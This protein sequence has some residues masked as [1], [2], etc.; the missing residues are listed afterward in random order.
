MSGNELVYG[1]TYSVVIE[2][3]I[4]AFSREMIYTAVLS[5][6]GAV[7][8]RADFSPYTGLSAWEGDPEVTD[9][10]ERDDAL[11]HELEKCATSA[12][13]GKPHQIAEGSRLHHGADEAR[14]PLW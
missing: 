7:V 8:A 5:V 2:D 4:G 14:M 12:Y 6:D 3:D 1:K 9:V 11:A 13:W 10:I